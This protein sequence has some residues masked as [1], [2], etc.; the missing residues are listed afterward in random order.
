VKDDYVRGSAR[1]NGRKVS[2]TYD[3]PLFDPPRVPLPKP[4][5]EVA[6]HDRDFK[7]VDWFGVIF[8]F[9]GAQCG[10]VAHLWKA[11]EDGIGGVSQLVLLDGAD[12]E[13]SRLRDLFRA[14]PAWET[15]IVPDHDAGAGHYKLSRQV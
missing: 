1:L 12:C 10:V 8:E 15:M 4:T 7:W 11:S 6:S 9:V 5:K 14:H 2:V 3:I 13:K